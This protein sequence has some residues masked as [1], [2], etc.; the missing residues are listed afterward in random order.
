LE[1]GAFLVGGCAGLL[2][3]SR[4][5]A[6]GF[7]S[8]VAQIRARGGTVSAGP[9]WQACN[10]LGLVESPLLQ[11]RGHFYVGHGCCGGESIAAAMARPVVMIYRTERQAAM[12]ETKGVQTYAPMVGDVCVAWE[13]QASGR[14]SETGPVARGRLS[15]EQQQMSCEISWRGTAGIGSVQWWVLG[16]GEERPTL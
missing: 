8:I 13:H 15:G 12:V 14:R 10:D 3:G 7:G 11:L 4:V 6:Q 9:L 16:R 2:R 1:D 5:Y